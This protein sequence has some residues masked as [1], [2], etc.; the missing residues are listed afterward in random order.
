MKL[1]NFFLIIS[2]LFLISN[3]AFAQSNKANDRAVKATDKL[4]AKLKSQNPD[5][6]LSASQRAQI[7]ELQVH[8]MEEVSAYR[9]ANS[10]KE[11]VKA[12]SKELNKA[13]KA[14]ISNEILTPEQSK[15]QKAAGKKGKGAA[16]TGKTPKKKRMKK[17][18]HPVQTMTDVEV[19]E[20][21]ASASDKEKAKAEKSTQKLND[22]ITALDASLALSA[23]QK[24]QINALNLKRVLAQAKMTKE[25]LSKEE[26]KVKNK[27]LTK[28]NKRIIKSILTK[29]QNAAN[30]GA[31]KKK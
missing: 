8:R 3:T 27:E 14:K 6:A 19:D 15:A 12:K 11:E 4:D 30:K 2:T 21:F 22:G 13:M 24:K 18:K 9:K 25:G 28:S 31:K 16:K 10:N 26:I 5:L 23:E 29:E 7:V 1:L 20:I 17:A